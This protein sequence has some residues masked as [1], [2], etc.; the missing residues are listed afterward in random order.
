MDAR[1]SGFA[2][3]PRPRL[4]RKVGVPK[5]SLIAVID[6]DDSFRAALCELLFSFG[7]EVRDFASAEDFLATNPFDSYGCIISDIHMPG[8]NG[9]DLQHH[10]TAHGSRVPVIMITA[11]MEPGLEGRVKSSGAACLLTKPFEADALIGWI[12]KSL[13]V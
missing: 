13:G 8:M 4:S 9:I 3:C 10:L 7:Y 2:R 12:E 11:R 5:S 1:F 6:D